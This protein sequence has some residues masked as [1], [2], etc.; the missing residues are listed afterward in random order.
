MRDICAQMRENSI[1]V[2]KSAMVARSAFK[3]PFRLGSTIYELSELEAKNP[4]A[5]IRNAEGFAQEVRDVF[6]GVETPQE[7]SAHA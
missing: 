3:V 1:P 6:L 4:E 7:V 2:M 5:A